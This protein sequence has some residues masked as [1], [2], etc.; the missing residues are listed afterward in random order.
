MIKIEDS[1]SN[2]FLIGY[3]TVTDSYD[4]NMDSDSLIYG[5]FD[6]VELA[7]DWAKKLNGIS[8]VKAVYAPVYN[9]D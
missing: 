3:V 9:R 8:I 5:L 6:T 7:T 1:K 4:N 2:S